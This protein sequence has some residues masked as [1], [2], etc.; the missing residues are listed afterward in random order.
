MVV[1]LNIEYWALY[2]GFRKN[3]AIS[4]EE[5]T[6]C[7]TRT[8]R[9][10]P[11]EERWLVQSR[12]LCWGTTYLLLTS[13]KRVGIW[14]ASHEAI[15]SYWLDLPHHLQLPSPTNWNLTMAWRCTGSTNTEL[16]ANLKNKGIFNQDRIKE[17]S[18]TKIDS[19][20]ENRVR[21][22]CFS[23]PRPWRK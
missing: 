7:I 17:V 11:V 3:T 21:I 12:P 13:T 23:L 15:S 8:R 18:I 22:V 5:E 9:T 19:F 10:V 4:I 14:Q 1:V 6:L 2:R 20:Q 16:I